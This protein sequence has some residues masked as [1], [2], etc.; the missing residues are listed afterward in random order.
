M[1]YCI[2]ELTFLR[3]TNLCT[4]CFQNTFQKLNLQL[5]G[6]GENMSQYYANYR[7]SGL[8]IMESLQTNTT[9]RGNSM[10]SSWSIVKRSK[11]GSKSK[12]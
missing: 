4:Q 1:S 12:F 8:E 2:T 10:L 3:S 9:A 11:I 6:T 5:S 7:L